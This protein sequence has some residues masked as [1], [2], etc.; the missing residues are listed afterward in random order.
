MDDSE[1][2]S[3]R[4]N[5]E[6]D[7]P[8]RQKVTAKIY[9]RTVIAPPQSRTAM[10]LG[11]DSA[12]PLNPILT[13]L[14]SR[15]ACN[16]ADL[17]VGKGEGSSSAISNRAKLRKT[18]QNIAEDGGFL[19]PD[20]N[21]SCN[22]LQLEYVKPIIDNVNGSVMIP[23]DVVN[24]GSIPYSRTL[25]GFFIE[26]REID[27]S[28]VNSHFRNMWKIHGV[29]DIMANDKG[30][31]FFKFKT[32]E[33][34]LQALEHGPWTISNTKGLFDVFLTRASQK[35][36]QDSVQSH[37]TTS[38]P[39]YSKLPPATLPTTGVAG[40]I[41]D[42]T[43]HDKLKFPVWIRI[44]DMPLELWNKNGLSIIASMLGN[45]LAVDSCTG[46]MC[47]NASGRAGYARV[48]VDFEATGNWP[49][50][51]AVSVPYGNG[52]SLSTLRIEYSWKPD[53]CSFCKVFDHTDSNCIQQKNMKKD[54]DNQLNEIRLKKE[55]EEREKKRRYKA[56]PHLYTIIKEEVAKE[57]GVPVQFQRF[58]FWAKRQNNTYRPN[59]P[60][61]PQEETQLVGKLSEASN[62]KNNAELKLFLEIEIGLDLHPVPPPE[63]SKDDILV[64]FKLYDP[65]KEQLRYVGRFFVKKY[66]KPSEIISKLNERA[67][68]SP[69][70]ELELYEE[71]KSKPSVM[72]LRLDKTTSFE[73][74]EA[75]V[76]WIT[77]F[78]SLLSDPRTTNEDLRLFPSAVHFQDA[79][80]AQD[81]DGNLAKNTTNVVYKESM[82][83]SESR[84]NKEDGVPV[85][86]KVTAKIYPAKSTVIAP[87]GLG[88]D[89]AA[90][91][92]ATR[93]GHYSR[94]PCNIADLDVGGGEG[95]SS[96]I[97]NRAKL[98]RRFHNVA[99]DDDFLSPDENP[100]CH[101][102]QLEY[103]KP[104]ISNVNGSVIIPSDIVNRGSIPYSRTLY[105]FFNEE[106]E[107][108]FALVNSHFR[109]MWKTHGVEDIMVNDDGFYFFKFK[110]DE[111]ILCALE[112]GPWTISNTNSPIF[113]KR[114]SPGLILEKSKHDKLKLPVWI[115]IY[116][117]PLELWNKNGM[118]IIA[119][120]LGNPLAVDSC[121]ARMCMNGSGR[122]GYARV[123][124]DFEAT[125]KWPDEIS[126]SVPCGNG[127]SL[128][129]LRIEY[130][131]TPDKCSFCKVF[132]HSD[133]N[134]IQQKNRQ[135]DK[136]NQL[137]EIR[138][139]KE[140]EK[141]E[142]KRRYKARPDRYTLIKVVA[143]D[144][145][146]LEQIGKDIFFDLVDHDK[147]H[148]FYVKKETPFNL[149]KEVVAKE[150]DVPV[151][152]QRFWFW[153][154]R[155]N[156]TYRPNRPLTPQEGTQLKDLY[157]QESF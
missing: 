157:A 29:E 146:L 136:D 52:H 94:K 128:S 41:L 77:P 5:K 21:P 76:E 117:M 115:R 30:F 100:S 124:V 155:Q 2:R 139:K 88:D 103:V 105:G 16:I 35:K 72:C 130:S 45:P 33:G 132:D 80:C 57:F 123:L 93:T 113:L 126:V 54:K 118:N 145:D 70:E 67:G 73:S 144:E 111:G 61:T 12:A 153:V 28:L 86:Q 60:L 101:D 46:R 109:K 69:D 3:N 149:F 129:T 20:E 133:S 81:N 31:Y 112:H 142:N 40:L 151:Q 79:S 121:T 64:F 9:P 119:S 90:P 25:H 143:R 92:N 137:N 87:M 66:G 154:K 43:K 18:F 50:E 97:F 95:S 13:G 98:Q 84:R 108:D 53:K 39:P 96:A 59:R 6:D 91:S 120:M 19:S 15:K 148:C 17:D 42:K 107:I 4:R 7:I 11:D 131:W 14:H 56:H 63:K 140:E 34:M 37:Y 122:A 10:G 71:I 62:E 23:S 44:Y 104:V 74:S 99:E 47:M 127:F 125:G 138:L 152:F 27:F 141:R 26:D 32:N 102:L 75:F 49:D 82:D 51:I 89:S 58:W 116:G 135:K 1:Y 110:T 85:P 68:F 65:E 24:S 78:V 38:P 36:K 106:N 114:W 150:F 147:V 8:V 134:C 156:D 48:L 83:G 22:D 55:E